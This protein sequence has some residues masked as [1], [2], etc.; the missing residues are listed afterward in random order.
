MD[1]KERIQT[2]KDKLNHYNH[3]Y[4]VLDNPSISDAKYDALMNELIKLE[5]ENPDLRTSDSPSQRV[6]GEVSDKFEKVKHDRPMLS[7]GNVFNEEELR[8]FDQ[9]IKK[10]VTD[11]TY[12]VELKIDGLSVSIIYEDGKYQRA[13]T[14]GNSE[15]GEDI[16]KNV[17]TI[18]SIPLKIDF[19]DKLEVRG[20]IFLSKDRF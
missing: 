5:E 11:Y 15:V 2:L 9:R 20:E 8:Q 16:T 14:R 4:Y 3:E 10:S 18:K 17:K 1:V 7:L 6:G 13:A 19:K 12:T